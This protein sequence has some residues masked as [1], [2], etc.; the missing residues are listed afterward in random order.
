MRFLLAREREP[1]GL[2]DTETMARNNIP[3]WQVMDTTDYP[4]GRNRVCDFADLWS[5]SRADRFLLLALARNAECIVE[6]LEN[7]GTWKEGRAWS[8][9]KAVNDPRYAYLADPFGTAEGLALDSKHIYLVIDNNRSGRVA[10]PK[11]RRST[12]FIFKR[13]AD[14]VLPLLSDSERAH[15]KETRRINLDKP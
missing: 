6:L 12:L 9:A 4:P 2:L 11:D 1:R 10:N 13:P 5:E 15:P 3:R 8:F 14:L 7:H